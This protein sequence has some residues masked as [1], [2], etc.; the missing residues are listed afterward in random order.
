MAYL[1]WIFV[2]HKA[3]EPI[4]QWT[5]R[6]MFLVSSCGLG[7]SRVQS[8][9]AHNTNPAHEALLG[10]PMS[11]LKRPVGQ[12]QR[13]QSTVGE[14]SPLRRYAM[15]CPFVCVH[16]PHKAG[17]VDSPQERGN[18]ALWTNPRAKPSGPLAARLMARRRCVMP[19]GPSSSAS[20]CRVMRST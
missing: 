19:S 9:S 5:W 8:A 20:C 4:N 1:S 16:G 2:V 18:S 3:G 7:F 14:Q 12:Q 17:G 15:L 6:S 11:A 10:I 13:S